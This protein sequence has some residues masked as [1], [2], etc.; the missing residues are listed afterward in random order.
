[1]ESA[2]RV[3]SKVDCGDCTFLL[4]GASDGCMPAAF[5]AKQF[6]DITLSLTFLSCVPGREQ[7]GDVAR[8]HCPVTVTCG[9]AEQFFGGAVS[10]YLFAQTVHGDVFAF[11]GQHLYEG[12]DTLRRLASFVGDAS[13][14]AASAPTSP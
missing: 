1:M 10:M 3:A 12:Q 7:W 6:A 2:A 5:F 4:V 9:S 13:K 11:W 8:L 14:P